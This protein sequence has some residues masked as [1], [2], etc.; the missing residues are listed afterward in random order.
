MLYSVLD[1][2]IWYYFC[3]RIRCCERGSF[4]AAE[5]D[6]VCKAPDLPQLLKT[7]VLQ[8]PKNCQYDL[9]GDSVE[10]TPKA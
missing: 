4:V 2:T 6:F 7:L 9:G 5:H 10:Y 8:G 3:F 1:Y